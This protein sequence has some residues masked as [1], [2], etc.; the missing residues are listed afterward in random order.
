MCRCCLHIA[1]EFTTG[2]LKHGSGVFLSTA[3]N[4]TLMALNSRFK[5]V[6]V[7]LSTGATRLNY[8]YNSWMDDDDLDMT[9]PNKLPH[10]AESKEQDSPNRLGYK[11]QDLPH[12]ARCIWTTFGEHLCQEQLQ[13]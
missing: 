4:E 1:C 10:Q 12:Q 6:L 7:L 11:V 9:S 8:N 13:A 3:H 5:S 2:F